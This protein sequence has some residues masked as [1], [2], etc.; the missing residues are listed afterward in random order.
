VDTQWPGEKIEKRYSN[1]N[2]NLAKNCMAQYLE[3]PELLRL[4]LD[5]GQVQQL[6]QQDL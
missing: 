1:K 6:G 3:W 4:V 5:E 2:K